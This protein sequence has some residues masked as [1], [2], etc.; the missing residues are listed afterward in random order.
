MSALRKPNLPHN[1][2]VLDLRAVL[3]E[4]RAAATRKK[5]TGLIDRFRSVPAAPKVELSQPSIPRD[6][7]MVRREVAKFIM[8]L[9]VAG[10]PLWLAISAVQLTHGAGRIQGLGRQGLAEL[11]AGG[12]ALGQLKTTEADQAFQASEQTFSAVAKQVQQSSW[13][14]VTW[15]YP[16]PWIGPRLE[17]ADA[18]AAAGIDLAQ[19]GRIVAGQLAADP[20]EQIE[21]SLETEGIVAGS[22]GWL[23][24][25]FQSPE[26]LK[27]VLDKLEAVRTHLSQ[28][29]PSALPSGTQELFQA[30]Q[31]A[32]ASILGE[33]ARFQYLANLLVGLF[34]QTEPQEYLIIFQNHDELRATGGFAGTFLLVKFEDGGF[35]VLDAPVNGPFDLTNQVPHTNLPPD[36]IL[37][38]A[39]YWTFHDANWFLDVPTSADFMMDF[40]EQAR[41]FR[42]NGVIW[43]TPQLVEDLLRITGPI[44]PAGY[45][46]EVTADNF[47]RAT[48]LQVEFG[49]SR[50]LNNP[51]EFLL[52][53]V[54]ELITRLSSISAPKAF[55]VAA[56]VMTNAA[57]QN[58]MIT[59]E[60][61]DLQQTIHNLGWSGQLVET[62][63]DYLAVVDS[64]LGGG[65][66]DRVIQ[67]RNA[68]EVVRTENGLEHRLVITRQHNGQAGDQLT[69]STNRD[70]IRVY[71]PPT[72]DLIGIEGASRPATSMF[73]PAE[74][75][76]V[77]M[78]S[79]QG[80]EGNVLIDQ[81]NHYRFT[82]ESGRQVFGFWSLLPVG[83]EQTITVRYRLPWSSDQA[84]WRLIWQKQPGAPQRTWSV[85]Y[86]D[87]DRNLRQA[88]PQPKRD[89]KH[90]VLWE[91]NS[92]ISRGFSI[93][94]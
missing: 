56:T 4:R 49:Y 3:A 5:T 83:E 94:W 88:F 60:T 64:N 10:V 73:L 93:G 39:P 81:A 18:L 11:Q 82:Q 30:W 74:P 84:D 26:R 63:D 58:L 48:E 55:Q 38:I 57:E 85:L 31:L 78:E 40:Y 24:P 28:I 25:M 21:P 68:L 90:E 52:D 32:E 12:Q 67:V 17:A 33:P 34:A 20:P 46:T 80:V 71:V 59:S 43:V 9:G 8:V 13:T 89:A 77:R 35:K 29:S 45:T 44:K 1:P 69:G 22:L 36:P 66:T 79:L 2:N 75:G 6:W 41:G 86:R 23:A 65:K 87:E 15:W 62:T 16:V 47:V 70:F 61:S 50:E 37:A 7:A 19:A 51:K 92:D 72:A 27:V 53:L 91:T 54:P 14:P 42:P 76:A